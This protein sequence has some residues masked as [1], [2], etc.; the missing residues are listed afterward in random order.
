MFRKTFA[1]I[2]LLAIKNN[3]NAIKKF[4]GKDLKVIL[5]VKSNAYGHG[6]VEVSRFVEENKIVN[7]LAVAT[8]DE[9]VEL[10]NSGITLPI[11]VLCLILPDED[12]INILFDYNLTQTV[13]DAELARKISKVGQKR[14]KTIRLHLNIDTGMGR[15]G[16]KSE[17]AIKII[18]EIHSLKYINLEGI[19]S[20]FPVSD[21][22]D[23]EYT[24][25]QIS[26]FNK[27]IKTIQTNGLDIPIKHISNSAGIA[28]YPEASFDMIRPGIMAYGYLPSPAMNNTINIQPAMTLKSCI[29]FLKR[30]PENTPLCY[31]LTYTTNSDANI[32]TIPIG[33]GDGYNRFLSNKGKVLIRNKIYPV[34]GRVSMDQI[35]VNLGNDEYPVG[36]EVI[37]F[38]KEIITVNTVADWIGTISYEVTCA[39]S[40]RVPR[41][42]MPTE[43]Y[44]LKNIRQD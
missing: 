17:G 37:L 28:L 1:E 5:P 18:K 20:H 26:K 10:R 32:A 9:G 41:I 6:I 14:Q 35:L 24:K 8:L 39:I 27:I 44:K 36:E 25:N 31:G 38:G 40:D 19:Y 13:A 4:A 16:C 3:I 33:Y 2:D 43:N 12:Q 30:V 15:I 29:M 34:V 23:S 21:E 42:Y 7:M 11:L 22:K